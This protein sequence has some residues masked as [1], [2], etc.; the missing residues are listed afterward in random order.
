MFSSSTEGAED[1]T[2][3][4]LDAISRLLTKPFSK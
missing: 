2:K 4:E 1:L 3:G